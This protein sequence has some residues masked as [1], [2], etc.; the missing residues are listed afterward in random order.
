MLELVDVV[1]FGHELLLK[2]G[3]VVLE[4]EDFELFLVKGFLVE[5]EFLVGL[6]DAQVELLV[7][8]L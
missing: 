1:L 2:L 5:E 3:E 4:G 7:L 8:L 6:L